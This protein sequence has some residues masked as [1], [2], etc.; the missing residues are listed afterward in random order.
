MAGATMKCETCWAWKRFPESYATSGGSCRRRAP[1]LLHSEHG[2][3]GALEDRSWPRTDALDVCGDW[4][5][6]EPERRPQ[7]FAR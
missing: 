6:R 4:D 7:T 3:A 1:I 5:D 2:V